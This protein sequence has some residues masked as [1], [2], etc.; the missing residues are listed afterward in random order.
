MIGAGLRI[1]VVGGG[2]GGLGTARALRQR[3]LADDVVEREP[4]WTHTG[5]A[6]TYQPTQPG[7][8]VLLPGVRGCRT[9]IADPAPTSLRPPGPPAGR[10][11]P[12]R[13]AARCRPLPGA[14][15]RGPARGPGIPRRSRA[16]PDGRIAAAA[17]PAGRHRNRRVRRRHHRPLRPG[18]RRRRHPLHG[19]P[20][21]RRRRR[22]PPTWAARLALRHRLSTGGD[23]VDGAA[24]PRRQLPG[25]ADRP[26][27]GS[28]ATATGPP[29]A[30]P[31]WRATR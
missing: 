6:S 21:R 29:T 26:G 15:P 13:P 22:G 12:R 28:T 9:G 5:A 24:G 10:H 2:I 30:P 27:A 8:C 19:P 16:G 7:R 11:R 25:R 23:H 1:L 4:C 14:A 31:G 18:H 3:G 17:Q 20:A